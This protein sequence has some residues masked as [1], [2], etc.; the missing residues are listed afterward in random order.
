MGSGSALIFVHFEED[1][2]R[3]LSFMLVPALALATEPRRGTRVWVRSQVLETLR[4][5]YVRTARAKGIGGV[6]LI[7][8]TVLRNALLPV[9]TLLGSQFI[10]LVSGA[11]VVETISASPG[12]GTTLVG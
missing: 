12:I 2:I 4:E 5:D 3:N 9:I 6:S 10:F 7:S 1:P 8:R 11:V